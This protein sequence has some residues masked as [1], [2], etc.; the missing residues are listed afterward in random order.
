[1]G[2]NGHNNQNPNEGAPASEVWQSL[3]A[4][5]NK[6]PLEIPDSWSENTS[7]HWDSEELSLVVSV[8]SDTGE[9]WLERRFL[10]LARIYFSETHKQKHLLIQRKAAAGIDDVLVRI[11]RNVYEQIVEPE[12]IVP[13]Q[14]YL[15]R[16]WLP[17]LG[18]SP[19]WVTTAM[20]QVSFVSKAEEEKVVKL[21]STRVL[22]KWTPMRYVQVSEWLK[23]DGYTSW[24]FEKVKDA[25]EDVPPEYMVWSQIPVAPHHL[26]WI[27]DYIKQHMDGA[28]A[29]EIIE[30]LLDRTGDIRRIKPGKIAVPDHYSSK[31]RTVLDLVS[32]LFPGKQGRGLSDLVFQLEHQ[33][34]RP[35]LAVTIPHYF[36]HFMDDMNANEAAL[37]WYLRSL[38]KEDQG[39]EVELSGFKT[40]EKALGC[41]NRTPQRLIEKCLQSTFGEEGAGWDPIYRPEISLGNWLSAE[42]LGDFEKGAA[43]EY[44]IR[45]RTTEPIHGDDEGYYNR[46]IKRLADDQASI[47]DISD[48]GTHFRTGDTQKQTGEAQ[49]DVSLIN[50]Q[51]TQYRTGVA[52]IQTE[53][54][55]SLTGEV[56]IQT[57][58]SRNSEHLNNLNTNNSFNEFN[59][60]HLNQ[61]PPAQ[62]DLYL[63]TDQHV[64]GVG[65]INIDKLLGFGSYK[66]NEKKNLAN[67]IEKNMELF[68]AWIIRNHITEA[69]FPV[70]LAVKNIQEGNVTEDHYLEIARLGWSVSAQLARVN[71]NEL[72]MW[73]LGLDDGYEDQEDLIQS[74][75]KL[76]KIAKQEIG[77]L[78]ETNY[79]QLIENI[80]DYD[81]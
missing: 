10:P 35:N 59:N 29:A 64:V 77:K 56:Q 20:R 48:R 71:E 67:L 30:S 18:A 9:E 43:R 24:F 11:Q 51:D 47:N 32:E 74:Y 2:S 63:S 78:R 15:F 68:L 25:Y 21:I 46:L 38:Y 49:N 40:L 60:N 75:Q 44:K 53:D 54:A 65:L 81:Q 50:K 55:Q 33:I 79:S 3:L 37:I 52:Q 6:T 69:K 5:L 16:H 66:H 17:V 80:S 27:E 57:G 36:Y 1:M 58:S 8:P 62:N 70:R 76:S 23:K 45:V 22:A 26:A 13:V 41:G 28:S 31:R 61:P 4:E 7:A 19:F 72:S 39:S 34:T 42:Y 12:K 14:I 73:G